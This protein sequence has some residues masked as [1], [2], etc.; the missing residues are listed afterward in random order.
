LSPIKRQRRFR[1]APILILAT[2]V[3]FSF[4]TEFLELNHLE[5]RMN[6]TIIITAKNSSLEII[7]NPNHKSWSD[8]G[9]DVGLIN[10]TNTTNVTN[11]AN[12]TR[13]NLN[14]HTTKQPILTLLVMLNGEFGNNMFK[15]IRGWGT[16]RLAQQEFGMTTRIVF[17]EQTRRGKVTGKAKTTTRTVKKC[18]VS[19]S[20]IHTQDFELGNQLL[21]EGYFDEIE[22]IP[23]SNFT[24]SDEQS[25]IQDLREHLQRLSNHL[26]SHPQLTQNDNNDN[27]NNN[28][29][30]I[31]D[32]ESIV[33][34]LMVRVDALTI[35]P[36]VNE[37]YDDFRKTFVFDDNGCCGKTLE[38]PPKDDETVLYLRNYATEIRKEHRRKSHG[39]Q[40]LDTD[41]LLSQVLGH[42]KPNDKLAL[43][44]RNL[45]LDAQD[46]TTQ[47]YEI[48]QGLYAKNLT[49]QQQLRFTPGTDEMEDFCFLTHSKKELIGTP[50]STYLELASYMAGPSLQLVREYQYVT[51]ELEVSKFQ[52]F[53]QTVGSNNWTHP[54]LKSRIRFEEYY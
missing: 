30:T 11:T 45:K 2:I 31:Q 12:H 9:L 37:Y 8:S 24:L 7:S 47:V 29:T 53:Q 50:A 33:P 26:A 51:P 49:Q 34:R 42:L 46:N 19:P 3:C 52:R 48:I 17:A 4:L 22:S 15:I 40:E 39:F 1:L 5:K 13:V 10:H 21:M 18:W 25:S 23:G 20:I 6:N 14:D 41:R 28:S 35:Y 16:A 43:V 36:I 27:N 32:E 44:G 54:E 38:N